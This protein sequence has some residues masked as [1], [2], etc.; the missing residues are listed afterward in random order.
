MGAM[1]SP[2]SPVEE[3]DVNEFLYFLISAQPR[4]LP[5]DGPRGTSS[6]ARAAPCRA[7]HLALARHM[8]PQLGGAHQRRIYVGVGARLI[9]QRESPSTYL[10]ASID[11]VSG[12]PEPKARPAAG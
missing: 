9:T 4:Q 8:L 11:T 1:D 12:R 7:V 2:G 3:V 5:A 6:R 10:N